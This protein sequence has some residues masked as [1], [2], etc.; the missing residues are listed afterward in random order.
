MTGLESKINF[1]DII[2]MCVFLCRLYF[3]IPLPQNLQT[4]KGRMQGRGKDFDDVMM[5]KMMIIKGTNSLRG[6]LIQSPKK[7]CDGQEREVFSLTAEES[8]SQVRI[9]KCF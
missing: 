4:N 1:W 6:E 2:C 9:Q 7:E 3:L 5:Q 8:R